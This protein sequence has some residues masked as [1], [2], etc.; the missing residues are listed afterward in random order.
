MINLFGI[1]STILAVAGVVANN[2]RKAVCFYFWMV[3]NTITCGLHVS[4]GVGEYWPL[5]ARDIIFF[6]L[7]IDGLRRWGIR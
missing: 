4:A 3:A 5:I 2:N 7:A 1:I 6:I